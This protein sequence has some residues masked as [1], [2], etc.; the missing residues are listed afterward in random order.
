M[1]GFDLAVIGVIALSTLLAFARGF[2]RVVVSLAA[3]I[4][5]FVAAIRFS[6]PVAEL[7]PDFGAG[8]VGRHVAAMALIAIAILVLGAILGWALSRLIRAVG[9]G[10]LDRILGA[11]LGV[12]QGMLIVVLGVL[13][14]GLTDLPRRDWWQNS[15]LAPPL[16]AA[17]LSLKPWL[18]KA[19]SD[20][21]DYGGPGRIP[22][23]GKPPEAVT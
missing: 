3:W 10:F 16:V 17:A 4:V 14:A 7:L 23:K 11:L 5:A 2:V 19:W 20:K 21:L 8:S 18:P 22:R 13:I 6:T 12:A 15:T 9:L 1:T